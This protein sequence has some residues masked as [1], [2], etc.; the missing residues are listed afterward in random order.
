MFKKKTHTHT[1]NYRTLQGSIHIHSLANDA[2]I[3]VYM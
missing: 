1:H 2:L 3:Y